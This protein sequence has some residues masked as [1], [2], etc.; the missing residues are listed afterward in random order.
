MKKYNRKGS[1]LL[2]IFIFSFFIFTVNINDGTAVSGSSQ[3]P[4]LFVHGWTG[5]ASGWNTMKLRFYNDGW[6]GERLRAFTF[7]DNYN[8]TSEGNIVNAMSIKNWV[9]DFLNDTGADKIDIIAH[10]M[11]GLSSRYYIKSLSGIDKVDDFVSIASPHH[12]VYGGV[13]VFYSESTLL[14]SL[15]EGDETPGGILSDT[16]GFRGDP[17]GAR[18]YNGTHIPG[19]IKYTSIYSTEDGVVSPVISSELEG[20]DNIQVGGVD[21][22]SLIFDE[23]IYT[24]IKNAVYDPK[25]DANIPG[26]NLLIL[27]G[28]SSLLILV[29][30]RKQSSKHL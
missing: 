29:I 21:H 26:Y 7:I 9:D 14:V 8:Y 13:E 16:I 25:G 27:I 15:N 1:L 30:I 12:G 11:G 20:A 18:T 24:I 6:L 23:D 2:I 17:V 19:N 5:D 22:V 10:S 3:N 28:F 4:I